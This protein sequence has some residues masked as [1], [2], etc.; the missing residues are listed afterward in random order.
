MANQRKETAIAVLKAAL[1]YYA[2]R[3]IRIERAQE[4]RSPHD[5]LDA[6]VLA[7]GAVEP[8]GDRFR[9]G[10]DGGTRWFLRDKSVAEAHDRS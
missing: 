8:S 7:P 9:I 4:L 1:A 5:A 6:L 2:N 3:G 10:R